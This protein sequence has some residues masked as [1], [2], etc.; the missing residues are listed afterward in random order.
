MKKKL[1]RRN[2]KKWSEVLKLPFIYRVLIMNDR[3]NMKQKKRTDYKRVERY[4]LAYRFGSRGTI[5]VPVY[6][7]SHNKRSRIQNELDGKLAFIS[8]ERFN[9]RFSVT[10]KAED[11]P[12]RH[13]NGKALKD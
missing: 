13:F 12:L 9:E 3:A 8:I 7:S 2:C 4:D 5:M 6:R 1:K 11:L 10:Y